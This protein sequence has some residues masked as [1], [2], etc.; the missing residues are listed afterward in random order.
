MSF[1]L[2][3]QPG[4]SSNGWT[5]PKG[6]FQYTTISTLFRFMVERVS[7]SRYSTEGL[8]AT[9]GLYWLFP[10][11]AIVKSLKAL[12]RFELFPLYATLLLLLP[13]SLGNEVC[14]ACTGRRAEAK[15]MDAT[16]F[17][18]AVLETSWCICAQYVFVCS[19]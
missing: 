15:T 12:S 16:G 18:R 6:S 14:V 10:Y 9:M 11:T 3:A 8:Y 5:M 4:C 13:T 7:L 19:A 17:Q 2:A 1:T